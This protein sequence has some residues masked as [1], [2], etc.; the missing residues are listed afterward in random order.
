MKTFPVT[1]GE[2]R[3]HPESFS[4]DDLLAALRG[5]ERLEYSFECQSPRNSYQLN[6]TFDSAVKRQLLACGAREFRF[7]PSCTDSIDHGSGV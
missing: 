7:E 4:N 3:F 1:V 6:S 5:L 2:V